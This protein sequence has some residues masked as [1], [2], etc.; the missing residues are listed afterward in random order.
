MLRRAQR[1]LLLPG[2]LSIS[3]GPKGRQGHPS[4][5]LLLEPLVGSVQVFKHFQQAGSYLSLPGQHIRTGPWE[6]DKGV[7]GAPPGQGG[8]PEPTPVA[9]SGSRLALC[10]ENPSTPTHT[11]I[12]GAAGGLETGE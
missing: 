10:P 5:L 6:G 8:W 12:P 9:F 7:K 3:S 2:W 1:L 4:L 11:H